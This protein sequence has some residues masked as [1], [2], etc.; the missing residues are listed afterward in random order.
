MAV[1]TAEDIPGENGFSDYSREEPVLTPVGD[2]VRMVGAPIALVIA[3]TPSIAKAGL[4]AIAVDYEILP[5]IFEPAAA[6]TPGAVHIAGHSDNV[7]AAY[8]VKHG[9][10]DAAFSASA[11]TIEQEYRTAFLEHSALE[12]ETLLGYYDEEGRLTVTGGNHEPFHQQRYIANSLALPHERV[13]VI[14]PPTGGSFGGKQD[15]WPFIATALMTCALRRAWHSEA[16]AIDLFARRVVRCLAQTPPVRYFQ[17]GRR[18]GRRPVDGHPGAH[19]REHG[20]L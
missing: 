10:L 9:N 11:A 16:G 4:A 15:P 7:L 2:T 5:H 17:Q 3:E 14:M 12:R 19:R 13:H 6:L 20:R 8:A 18:D 1:L